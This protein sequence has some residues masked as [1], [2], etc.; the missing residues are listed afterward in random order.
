MNTRTQ[1]SSFSTFVAWLTG[2]SYLA[3]I[4]IIVVMVLLFALLATS[5]VAYAAPSGSGCLSAGC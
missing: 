2:H 5:G 3:R 1:L 4:T